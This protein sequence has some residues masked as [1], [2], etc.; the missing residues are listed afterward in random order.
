MARLIFQYDKV[1]TG[2]ATHNL[3]APLANRDDEALV[4]NLMKTFNSSHTLSLST[5]LGL[6]AIHLAAPA[7]KDM[8]DCDCNTVPKAPEWWSNDTTTTTTSKQ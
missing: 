4:Q 5:Q 1:M 2:P 7:G 3:I 6:T 8:K